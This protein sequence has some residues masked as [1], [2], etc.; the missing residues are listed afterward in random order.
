MKANINLNSLN[1]NQSDMYHRKHTCI[2]QYGNERCTDILRPSVLLFKHLQLP[3]KNL[4]YTYLLVYQR[5][6]D[7]NLYKDQFLLFSDRHTPVGG[8]PECL[9]YKHCP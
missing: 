3:I 7:F 6:L 8:V 2:W 4:F 9:K 5:D 1:P